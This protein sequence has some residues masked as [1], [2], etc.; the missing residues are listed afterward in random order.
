MLTCMST[1]RSNYFDMSIWKKTCR[2]QHYYYHKLIYLPVY[3]VVELGE[4][5]RER[6]S[7]RERE[8]E[9]ETETN[10]CKDPRSKNNDG[11]LFYCVLAYFSC[12]M[13]VWI[14]FIS[15]PCMVPIISG[16]WC[17]HLYKMQIEWIWS[18]WFVRARLTTRPPPK[19]D[20]LTQSIMSHVGGCVYVS[21]VTCPLPL[22]GD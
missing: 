13:Q 7:E 6:E 15:L 19:K 9:R 2:P 20:I 16:R 4:R 1:S 21:R 11:L 12:I 10:K 17:L 8:R 14:K 22:W 3:V 18:P 5:E